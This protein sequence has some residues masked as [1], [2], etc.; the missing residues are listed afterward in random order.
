MNISAGS[1]LAICIIL[2]I[3]ACFITLIIR[4]DDTTRIKRIL[5]AVIFI[6][7]ILYLIKLFLNPN[8]LPSIADWVYG[9]LR[10]ER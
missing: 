2:I 3:S 7:I 5:A 1:I 10:S 4:L 8:F 9:I 6:A